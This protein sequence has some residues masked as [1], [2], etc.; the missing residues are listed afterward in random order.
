MNSDISSLYLKDRYL[1]KDI[2]VIKNKVIIEYDLKSANTSLCR[3][4]NLLNDKLIEQ[5]E[6]STKKKRVVNIGKLQRKD[7]V[8]KEKLKESFIDIRRRFFIENN[9]HDDDIL[10]IK[11]DAIFC[12]KECRNVHFGRCHF[13]KKN[14]YTSYIYLNNLEIYYSPTGKNIMEPTVHVKGIDDVILEYHNDYMI[15]FFKSLFKHME[16]SSK[17]TTLQFY[18]RFVDKYKNLQLEIGYYREFNDMSVIRL[19]DAD[20]TYNDEIFIP[21]T[22]KQNHIQIDYN[23][24]NIIIPLFKILI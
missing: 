20:E 13:V 21:Y 23:Y 24:I 4:Y 7:S 16:T 19:I 14:V 12:L 15:S 1:N 8:F 5:L 11:K 18:R 10:S 17:S 22:D 2:S 9:I 3:E 6:S